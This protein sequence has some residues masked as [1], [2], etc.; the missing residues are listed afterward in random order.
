MASLENFARD[1][2]SILFV[3]NICDKNIAIL[4][5]STSA[6]SDWIQTL[7]LRIC[8]NSPTTGLPPL[9]KKKS[10]LASKPGHVQA[11]GSVRYDSQV[12]P[13]AQL[14]RRED[15]LDGSKEKAVV[16]HLVKFL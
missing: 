16:F 8:V 7:K 5:L 1:K 13:H 6:S 10:F 15:A 2:H 12:L 11:Q 4:S 9:T 14:L 3:R